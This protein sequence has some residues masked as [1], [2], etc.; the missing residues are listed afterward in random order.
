[1]SSDVTV[2]AEPGT[3]Q[4]ETIVK[5]G[6]EIERYSASGAIG[7]GEGTKAG[8]AYRLKDGLIVYVPD[9]GKPSA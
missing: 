1:M 6:E 8:V 7:D 3:A 5:R 2:L 4:V 9:T